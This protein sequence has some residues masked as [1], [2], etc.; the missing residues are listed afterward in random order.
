ME[1]YWD[2]F[3]HLNLH[4]KNKKSIILAGANAKD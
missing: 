3:L 1:K 4:K 2:F